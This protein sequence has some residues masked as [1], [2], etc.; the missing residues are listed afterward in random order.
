[1]RGIKAAGSDAEYISWFYQPQVRPER[2]AWVADVARHLPKG[3]TLAYNFE[4][5]AI[6]DQLGRFRNGGDYWLSFVGPAQGF[7]Q[8]ANA[9]R[10]AGTSLGA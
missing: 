5:G 9:S 3:V 4:S 10:Q 1:M 6:K 2:G 7:R 8:V